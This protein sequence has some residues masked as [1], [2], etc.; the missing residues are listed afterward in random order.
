MKERR[1]QRAES[2]E[3]RAENREQRAESREQRAESREQ[4]D[5]SQSSKQRA[6]MQG[7]M[8]SDSSESGHAPAYAYEWEFPMRLEPFFPIGEL[9]SPG[10]EPAGV[11]DGLTVTHSHCAA[12]R[13]G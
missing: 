10:R 9:L 1:D 6:A 11:R 5:A 2:R 13:A 8:E 3:Q 7:Q 4:I 12:K